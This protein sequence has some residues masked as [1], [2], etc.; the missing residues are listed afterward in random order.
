MI[1]LDGL[2]PVNDRQGHAY[3]DEL[4]TAFGRVLTSAFRPEDRTY[5]LGETSSLVLAHTQEGAEPAVQERVDRTART[6]RS[7]GFSEVRASLGVAYF[8]V[9]AWARPSCALPARGCYEN[10][11]GRQAL[12][13]AHAGM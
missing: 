2:K 11:A 1:D 12:A 6:V 13:S 3:G 8:P 5:R 9:T 7:R 4:L 10:K